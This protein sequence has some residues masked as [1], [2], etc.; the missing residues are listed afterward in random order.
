MNRDKQFNNY[1][2]EIIQSEEERGKRMKRNE[3][4][5]CKIR[6]RLQQIYKVPPFKELMKKYNPQV[7]RRRHFCKTKKTS[8]VNLSQDF[9]VVSPL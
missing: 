9:P 3:T 8:P 4:E 7:I 2:F 1:P 6:Q 5:S